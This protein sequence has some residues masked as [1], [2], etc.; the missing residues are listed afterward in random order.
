MKQKTVATILEDRKKIRHAK[1][2]IGSNLRRNSGQLKNPRESLG[3]RGPNLGEKG[4][5]LENESV[6]FGERC[7]GVEER[8]RA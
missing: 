4:G 6:L 8:M 7:D 3:E 5:N 1:R 2:Q